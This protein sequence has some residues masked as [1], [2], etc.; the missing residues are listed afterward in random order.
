[1]KYTQEE[2]MKKGA[3]LFGND[4]K[5]WKFRC[6]ACKREQSIGDFEEFKSKGATPNTAYQECVGRYTG[7]RSG[8]DKCDW[9]AFGLLR[10][11]D[12]VIADDGR[13]VWVF[14]FATPENLTGPLIGGV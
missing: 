14:P 11:P 2:W 7:G 4:Y 12:C 9:A 5:K 13:E 8:P 3:E 1:M 6:P 10:G